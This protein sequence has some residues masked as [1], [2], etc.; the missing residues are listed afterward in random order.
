MSQIRHIKSLLEEGDNHP[1][2]SKLTPEEHQTLRCLGLKRTPEIEAKLREWAEAE[3]AERQAYAAGCTDTMHDLKPALFPDKY[4][5][6][7]EDIEK[8]KVGAI[9]AH[10]P[11]ERLA[12][13][14][15]LVEK[16]DISLEDE[17]RTADEP[18]LRAVLYARVSMFFDVNVEDS[19]KIKNLVD[20]D[21]ALHC[22]RDLSVF[23]P[24]SSHFWV[25]S[26][27]EWRGRA[28]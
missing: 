11:A 26:A 20:G 8:P 12:E 16:M 24:M 5:H 1:E 18:F 6:L 15:P 27:G 7:V 3:V 21:Q 4:W 2:E 19:P 9:W 28:G 13:I 23:P 25:T 17:S 22:A 14:I 10:Y